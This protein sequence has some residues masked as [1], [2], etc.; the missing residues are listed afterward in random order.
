MQGPTH[1][2]KT[3]SIFPQVSHGWMLS[4]NSVSVRAVLKYVESML[5][6]MNKNQ[7][8]KEGV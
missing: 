4:S 2:E 1:W 5:N 8:L 3:N 6:L 7:T